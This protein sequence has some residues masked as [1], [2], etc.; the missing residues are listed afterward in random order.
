MKKNHTRIVEFDS[1]F[2]YEKNHIR[3]YFSLVSLVRI[4]ITPTKK[5][6][7]GR[8]NIESERKQVSRI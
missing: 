7:S 1:R 6:K 2:E 8:K 5:R 4:Q 3:E